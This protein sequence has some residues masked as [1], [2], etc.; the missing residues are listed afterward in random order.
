[1]N[2]PSPTYCRV[3]IT[4][5]LLAFSLLWGI[6]NSLA[7]NN[8]VV[9]PGFEDSGVEGAEGWTFYITSPDGDGEAA[10][11]GSGQQ[12]AEQAH[13]GQ[14]SQH[15]ISEGPSWAGVYQM[16][17][18]LEPEAMYKLTVW[19]RTERDKQMVTMRVISPKQKQ[20]TEGTIDRQ[21][22]RDTRLPVEPT[23]A[24]Q[25]FSTT[26][27]IPSGVEVLRLDLRCRPRAGDPA[28]VWF[29]DVSFERVYDEQSTD[30]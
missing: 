4:F 30:D 25:E 29:D 2:L 5:W 6:P 28:E 16:V 12:D 20:D 15:I 27:V 21:F 23:G 22:G 3:S 7:D 10:T 8:L 24:W 13:T 19:A 17:S 9:N 18:N 11:G 14:Y 26:L 1:M